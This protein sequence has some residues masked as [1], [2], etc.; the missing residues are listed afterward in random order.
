MYLQPKIVD[1]TVAVMVA[2]IMTIDV[3]MCMNAITDM[4]VAAVVASVAAVTA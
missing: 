2:P 1:V 3:A 4:L